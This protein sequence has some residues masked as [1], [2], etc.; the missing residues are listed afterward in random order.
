MYRNRAPQLK[1]I[2]ADGKRLQP[3][4]KS[5]TL[6]AIEYPSVADTPLQSVELVAAAPEAADVG[7]GGF[8]PTAVRPTSTRKK[9]DCIA[10]RSTIHAVFTCDNGRPARRCD[11]LR[12]ASWSWDNFKRSV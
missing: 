9:P 8:A 5:D 2:R 4:G 12:L 1:Q 6:V 3:F 7:N 10:F 11:G